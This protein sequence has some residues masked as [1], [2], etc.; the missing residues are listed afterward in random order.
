MID[1][2][3]PIRHKILCHSANSHIGSKGEPPL[4]LSRAQSQ[5]YLNYAEA[6]QGRRDF[7]TAWRKVADSATYCLYH[8]G[9]F[10]DH[11]QLI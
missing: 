6:D 7:D 2:F 11:F 10:V 5:V 8:P 4:R 9:L 1:H 3:Q